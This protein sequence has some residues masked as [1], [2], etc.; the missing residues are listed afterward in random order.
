MTELKILGWR[1]TG[2]S[3]MPDWFFILRAGYWE[4]KETHEK[5]SEKAL[6]A[7]VFLCFLINIL[8]P[9]ISNNSLQNSLNGQT[10]L[11]LL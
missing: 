5:Q 7:P 10:L 11:K 4:N 3:I 1:F 2:T 8:V 9:L 6:K